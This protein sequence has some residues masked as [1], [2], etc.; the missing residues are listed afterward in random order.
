MA[1]DL[2]RRLLMPLLLVLIAAGATASERAIWVWETETLEMLDDRAQL[3]RYLTFLRENG[4]TTVYLYADS[5]RNR[6]PIADEREAFQTLVARFHEEGMEV[7]ALLGSAHLKTE[8]YVLVEKRDEA[9]E[10]VQRVLDYNT[11]AAEDGRLDGIHFDIEPHVLDLWDQDRAK[12][13]VLFLDLLEALGERIRQE[14]RPVEISAAIPFWFDRIDPLTWKE[15]SRPPNEHVQLLLDTAVLMDYRD[16]A[17]GNDGIVAHA[18]AE[19]AF[20]SANDRKV[21]VGVDTGKSKPEKVTFF[22]EGRA[23]MA[24]ELALA[25]ELMSGESSFAGFAIHHLQTWMALRK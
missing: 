1:P 25:E 20:A 2:I 13:L 17:E 11:V 3:D 24:R 8:E 21:I 22:A 4:V 18:R 9:M 15:K 10:M 14:K 16:K 12:T 7:H 5:Y 6:N 19:L 23:V